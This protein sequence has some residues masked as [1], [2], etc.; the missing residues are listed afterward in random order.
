MHDVLIRLEHICKSFAGMQALRDVSFDIYKGER[1]TLVGENGSGKSTLIKIIAGV[2]TFDSGTVEINGRRFTKISPKAAIDAGI[3]VIFQD[4]SLF[5]NLSVAEN[6]AFNYNLASGSLRMNWK[7]TC[8]L[9]RQALD[10]IKVDLPLDAPAGELSAADRQLIAIAKA[11]LKDTRLIIMD[12]P[13]TALTRREV[14]TLLQIIDEL[15]AEGISTV[16]VSHKLE[17]VLTVSDRL[18]ILRNGELISQRSI[19]EVTRASIV[20]DMSGIKL[21]EEKA[22]AKP[23]SGEPLLECE[24]LRQGAMQDVNL[25]LYKGHVLG[26]AG[27]LGSGRNELAE[28]LMGINPAVS[29]SIKLKGQELKI[30]SVKDA[31]NHKIGLVPEDRLTEGLFVSKPISVNMMCSVF[32]QKRTP[33]FTLKWADIN[34]TVWNWVG[35]LKI[36]AHDISL[37]AD[38]LSGGNQQKVVLA[39]WL[40][41]RPE[42]LILV[43]PTVGV[44]VKSKMEI[45]AKISELADAGMSLIV[46]SDDLPELLQV[47]NEI[48][49]MKKG[50]ITEVL[51]IADVD[52]G[53]L[54]HVLGSED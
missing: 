7:N 36:K 53:Y 44:D 2:Y 42:I 6:L 38:S 14:K 34:Q 28:S 16:F 26:I 13:T 46:I 39:K 15:K 3:Q 37:N 12:E 5:P 17:E 31:M 11:L 29:G 47:S 32:D 35:R 10:R 50:R 27:L 4:F 1:L 49:I 54:N 40:E 8:A 41:T 22:K 19:H 52:E 9:A 30:R 18:V 43:G 45:T 24:H 33:F 21:R 20:E 25:K 48:A 23:C 51:S